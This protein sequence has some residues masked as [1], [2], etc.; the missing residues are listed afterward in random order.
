M[1]RLSSF[2]FSYLGL[3]I[4]R[5]IRLNMPYDFIYC[6]TVCVREASPKGDFGA[7][8]GVDSAW[9]QKK[10]EAREM[11]ENTADSRASSARDVGQVLKDGFDSTRC[12]GWHHKSSQKTRDMDEATNSGGERK[13]SPC[14]RLFNFQRND[15]VVRK[16]EKVFDHDRTSGKI[17]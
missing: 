1:S 10:L 9:E 6:L 15:F 13:N 12:V 7:E 2:L 3:T 5:L 16:S 4:I 14:Q 17:A 11:L 8:A